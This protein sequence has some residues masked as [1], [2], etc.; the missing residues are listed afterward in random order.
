MLPN[1]TN[2]SMP[3]IEIGELIYEGA[4]IPGK[5]R[6]TSVVTKKM[7][8]PADIKQQ[9]VQWLIKT[10]MK[11]AIPMYTEMKSKYAMRV[12]FMFIDKTIEASTFPPKYCG[13]Y[14]KPEGLTLKT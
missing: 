6:G 9:F 4:T 7:F 2:F 5:S 8:I 10:Q 3:P 12:N 13:F 1:V 14:L 11:E